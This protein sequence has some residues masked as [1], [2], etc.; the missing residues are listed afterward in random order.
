MNLKIILIGIA[1]IIIGFV[2]LV[3]SIVLR[4][5]GS[6]ITSEGQA[7]GMVLDNLGEVA[8]NSNVDNIVNNAKSSISILELIPIMF[9]VVGF[10]ILIIGLI[11]E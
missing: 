7:M 6:E 8:N 1:L 2:S 5:A 3:P 9:I 11:V 4:V 10:I